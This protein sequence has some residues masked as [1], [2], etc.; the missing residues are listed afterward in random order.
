MA[1]S[2]NYLEIPSELVIMDA[3]CS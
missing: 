1:N 3:D 2:V